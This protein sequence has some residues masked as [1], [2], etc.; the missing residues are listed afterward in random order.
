MALYQFQCKDCGHHYSVEK[1]MK[2]EFKDEDKVCPECKVGEGVRVWA[3]TPMH[4]L[5]TRKGS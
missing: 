3:A 4:G 2:D 5:I 1:A